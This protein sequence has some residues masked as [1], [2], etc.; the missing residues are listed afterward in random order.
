M[1]KAKDGITEV[2]CATRNKRNNVGVLVMKKQE[3]YNQ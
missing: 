2:D 3:S 1:P